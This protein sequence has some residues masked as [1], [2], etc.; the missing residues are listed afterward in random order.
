MLS[1]RD[2]ILQLDRELAALGWKEARVE[3]A[4]ALPLG[5]KE[6]QQ[7]VA[8][9]MY[10]HDDLPYGFLSDDYNVRYIYGLR[11]E[12]EQYFLRYCRY[13]GPPEIVKDIVSRWDLPD[14]QRFILNSCYGEGDFSLPL[15]NADIAAIMLVN[16]PDLGFD[17]PRCQEYLH[18]W[19]SVA[20]KVI[21]KLDKVEN[22]NSLT[23][24]TREELMPRL[25]E[26]I[27]AALEQG[28]P[29]W[30]AL[31]YL[32]IHVSK[33]G[34][35]DRARLIG[36]FLSSIERAP[37][38]F[39]RHTMVNMFKENLAVTDAELYEHRHILI[40]HLVAGDLFFVK[41]FGRWLLPLLEG[42]ELVAA[43]TGA[44]G[45]KND[46]RKREILQ[47]LLDFEP[48]PKV[49]PELAACVRFLLNS[50]HRDGAKCAKKLSHA[51]GIPAEPDY[52]KR[53]SH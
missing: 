42:A 33:E 40:P 36:L 49:T 29:P 47:I 38:V 11:L 25:Q 4:A 27:A 17:I 12:K 20:A 9:I 48:P 22:P 8:S 10:L 24:P 39:L 3:Q 34:L 19:V 45:V 21:A 52:T 46:A 43:A 37:R 51:W 30:E 44:L 2:A 23:L 14:I 18:G 5:S 32:L 41:S 35:F 31:G 7:Q 50:P 53:A 6:F 1:S 15:R 26:H 28:I 16:D 13:D